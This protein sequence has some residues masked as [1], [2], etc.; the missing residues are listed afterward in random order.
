[1]KTS[2]N[3]AYTHIEL[4]TAGSSILNY[5]GLLVTGDTGASVG[6]GTIT[7]KTWHKDGSGNYMSY[8][9]PID[10][11]VARDMTTVVQFSPRT[12]EIITAGITI[13]GLR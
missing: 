4:V 12:I 1:M 7:G 2:D 8:T 10:S 9:L 11:T 6:P 5:R 13:Y 3:P